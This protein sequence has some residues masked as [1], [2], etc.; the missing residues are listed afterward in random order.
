MLPIELYY[1]FAI[2]C[3]VYAGLKGAGPERIGAAVILVG[4]ALT[5]VG[6]SGP[7]SRYTYV[8]SGALL[9]DG[10]ALVAFLFL[11]LRAERFWPLCVTALQ[12]VGTA[13][14]AVKLLDAEVLRAAYAFAMAVWS[15]PMWFLVV[16][17]T[18]NHQKRL[19]RNGVDRSWSSFSRRSGPR[20]PAGPI[21]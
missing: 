11:S 13:G 15:Y 10:A 14:H 12:I 3:S 19:A 20:P 16:L 4:S 18:W 1:A 6:M 17:G 7:S 8:E 2:V 21:D 9:V 5:T